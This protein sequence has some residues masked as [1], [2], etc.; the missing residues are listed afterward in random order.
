MGVSHNENAVRHFISDIL[1]EIVKE[2]P[3]IEFL[4]IGG[5]ALEDLRKLKSEYVHF[6]G[7]VDA[8]RDY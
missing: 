4:I 2:K 3:E 5:G 8:V 7:R 6:T 1:L